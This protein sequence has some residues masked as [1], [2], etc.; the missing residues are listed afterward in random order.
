M[1]LGERGWIFL[2]TFI[3]GKQLMAWRLLMENR[4]CGGSHA[5]PPCS[6]VLGITW[7]ISL[8][9]SSEQAGVW[10]VGHDF[11]ETLTLNS[12]TLDSIPLTLE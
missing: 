1:H 4:P 7:P 2:V 5:E 8:A 10:E 11:S 9:A 12:G 6:R 3:T